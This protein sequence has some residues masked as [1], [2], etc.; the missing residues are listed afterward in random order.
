MSWVTEL[1]MATCNQLL[2]TDRVYNATWAGCRWI[3]FNLFLLI[4]TVGNVQGWSAP[5]K[6]TGMTPW[7]RHGRRLRRGPP[8]VPQACN[9]FS[10]YF[11]LLCRGVTLA[12][13]TMAGPVHGATLANIKDLF[14]P[15]AIIMGMPVHCFTLYDYPSCV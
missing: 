5:A 10:W 14:N 8:R 6:P 11:V 7:S 13:S 15:G 12:E 3:S 2:R 1:V 9:L 4:R